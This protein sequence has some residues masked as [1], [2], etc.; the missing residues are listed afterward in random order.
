MSN[1]RAEEI[2]LKEIIEYHG[3]EGRPLAGMR[4]KARIAASMLLSDL[5][6]RVPNSGLACGLQKMRGVH[7]G[8]DVF[9]GREVHID[10]M[11]PEHITIESNVSIGMRTMIFAHSNPTNSIYLKENYYPRTIRDVHIENGVWIAPG[12]LILPGVRIGAKS[13][14]GAGSVVVKDVEPLSVVAGNPARLIKNIQ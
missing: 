3:L 9:I 1:N 7:I 6:K 12:C 14:V 10:E 2:N 5:A 4:V 13:V 11:Y 8:E